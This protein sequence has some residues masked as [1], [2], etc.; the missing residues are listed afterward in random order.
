[1]PSLNLKIGFYTPFIFGEEGV[2]QIKT[3]GFKCLNGFIQK[4]ERK[5]ERNRVCIY[6]LCVNT[7]ME[8]GKELIR[9]LQNEN[10]NSE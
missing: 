1:M 4:R 7:Y 10:K 8:M 9:V 2:L 3:E 6:F 5:R